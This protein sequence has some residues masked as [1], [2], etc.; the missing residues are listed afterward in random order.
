MPTALNRHNQEAYETVFRHPAAHNLEWRSLIAMFDE[1]GDLQSEP[2]GKYKFSHN[3]QILTFEVRGKD[4]EIEELMRVR[5]FLESTAQSPVDGAALKGDVIVVLDHAGARI[6]EARAEASQPVHMEPID[7]KGH[8]QH[9]HNPKGDSGGEQGPHRKLFYE[10]LAKKLEDAEHILMVGDGQ[11]ASS[12]IDRFLEELGHY[13]Q[14]DLAGR[15]VGKE[16]MDLHHMTE[17]EMLAK[18]RKFFVS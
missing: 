13:H 5:H 12:E 18:A 6:Y 11:G 3:G 1:L 7:P 4:V 16:T 15:I 9:V 2:N 14:H 10:G 8:D 17:A